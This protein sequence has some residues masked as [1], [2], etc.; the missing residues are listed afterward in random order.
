MTTPADRRPALA[1]PG[2]DRSAHE[3]S[4]AGLLDSLRADAATRVLVVHGDAV[5]LAAEGA[6]ERRSGAGAERLGRHPWHGR[7][8]APFI[9]WRPATVPTPR[10]GHS[11][12]ATARRGRRLRHIRPEMPRHPS[13]RPADGGACAPSGAFCRST[14]AALFVEALSLGRWLLD[15]PYCPACGTRTEVRNAGWSRHCPQCGREH[16]PRTDP[17]VIVAVTS[18]AGPR[19][20]SARLERG[21]GRRPVL[22]LRRLRRGGGVPRVDGR[23]RGAR[24][25]RC[26]GRATSAT[27]GR[28]PGRTRDRSWSASMRR[29]WTTRRR[30]ADGDEIAAVRWFT[31]NEIG[32]RLRAK[33]TSCFPAARRS[34]TASSPTGSQVRA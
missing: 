14:E 31:R 33:A 5:P 34:P 23:A 24:G 9:S 4:E 6:A 10:N 22:L 30:E 28:R 13:R 27:A 29:L 18:A 3:R 16:F 2:L 20:A 19:S 12:A 25:G 7:A 26:R 15:A 32:R 1:G 17:A 11:S 21:V 8:S